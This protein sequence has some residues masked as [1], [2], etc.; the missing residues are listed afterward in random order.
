MQTEVEDQESG[1]C[2]MEYEGEQRF[3]ER[4]EQY[5]N[6]NDNMMVEIEELELLLG[7]EDLEVDVRQISRY[8]RRKKGRRIFE[9]F[10]S[11]GQGESLVASG[12]RWDE[13]QRVLVTQ[14]EES[15]GKAQEVG[16]GVNQSWAAV[17]QG[18]W[19]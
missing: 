16:C 4:L 6:E 2:E 10:T 13:R 19:E 17:C 9:I 12:V 15:R 14:E 8:A 7:P 3:I 5:L 18:I 1:S 11:K